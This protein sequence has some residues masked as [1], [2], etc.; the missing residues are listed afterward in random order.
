MMQNDE[1]IAP[2]N[3][4]LKELLQKME[5]AQ[6]SGETLSPQMF[7][8]TMELVALQMEGEKAELYDV[9][10]FEIDLEERNLPVRLYRPSGEKNLPI[11]L[12]FHGGGWVGGNRTTHDG[13]CRNLS[14]FSDAQVLSVEYRLAPEH[15]YPAAV[16]DA[17]ET[18]EWVRKNA[19]KLGADAERIGLS[20]DSAGGNL[21]ANIAMKFAGESGPCAQV[22]F[23]PSLNQVAKTASKTTFGKGYMLD[24]CQMEWFLQ[25]YGGGKLDL[26]DPRI[27]PWFGPVSEHYPHTLVVTGGYD[28]LRD[29]GIAFAEKLKEKGVEASWSC[30]G[31]MVHGFSC[32]GVL[33]RAV[34]SV[35]EAGEYF[36][37]VFAEHKFVAEIRE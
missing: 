7:R 13:L 15:P 36:Q 27:S 30:Y 12:F 2:M 6:L 3:E 25:Q 17:L 24:L 4:I 18:F 32:F 33:P 37:K 29:E 20:G 11:V 9:A 26:Q 16:E 5:N 31:E 35:R 19:E 23:C 22:M 34:D 21:T 1:L 28:P 8:G 14:R 10:D